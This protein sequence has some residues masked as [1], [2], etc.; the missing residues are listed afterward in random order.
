[1]KKFTWKYK[2]SYR[3][4]Y[5]AEAVQGERKEDVD[6]D[7][8]YTVWKCKVGTEDNVLMSF[9]IE[10]QLDIDPLL[11]DVI[12]YY[13]QAVNSLGMEWVHWNPRPEVME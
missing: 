7:F 9:E 3:N 13:I 12:R 11:L 8:F 5:V 1:M 2:D 4:Y 6:P 10:T